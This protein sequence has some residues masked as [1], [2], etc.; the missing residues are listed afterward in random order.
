MMT[1]INNEHS[2]LYVQFYFACSFFPKYFNFPFLIAFLTSKSS[3]IKITDTQ[4]KIY[5][6]NLK[7]TPGYN[8]NTIKAKVF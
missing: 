7:I 1:M 6:H 4:F 5:L 2:T 3:N 8:L